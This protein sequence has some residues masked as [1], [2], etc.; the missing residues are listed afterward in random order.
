[1]CH[2]RHELEE[3][4]DRR[5]ERG[6]T[7]HLEEVLGNGERVVVVV[8]T[9]GV[10]AYRVTPAEDRNF[11]VLTVRDGRIV[12]FRECRDRGEA[13]AVAGIQ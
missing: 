12:A 4:L 7:S 6:L 13:L 9:P 11:T 1:V 3:A 10:D 2:G 8:R 5:A